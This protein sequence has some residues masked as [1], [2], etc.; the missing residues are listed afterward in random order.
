MNKDFLILVFIIA[1]V[2]AQFAGSVCND[3]TY[4][5]SYRLFNRLIWFIAV[6][7]I[8]LSSLGWILLTIKY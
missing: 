4:S 1:Y 6:I 3:T 7:T 8:V 5:Q 2:V